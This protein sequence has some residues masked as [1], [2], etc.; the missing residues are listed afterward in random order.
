MSALIDESNIDGDVLGFYFGRLPLEEMR[1]EPG[2]PVAVV[3]VFTGAQLDERFYVN[4]ARAF[5]RKVSGLFDEPVRISGRE[6]SE[7]LGGEFCAQ[8]FHE[9][10]IS[11][12]SRG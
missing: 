3:I 11:A 8:V 7:M 2:L 6:F 1:R 9:T 10:L 12:C 4:V 5:T